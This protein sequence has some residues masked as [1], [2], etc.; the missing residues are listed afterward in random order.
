MPCA[1][2]GRQA[3][4]P[5]P[6]R[7]PGSRASTAAGVPPCSAPPNRAQPSPGASFPAR[8]PSVAGERV[9]PRP[10]RLLNMDQGVLQTR[11][12]PGA[13]EPRGRNES[14][15]TCRRGGIPR[16]GLLRFY[17]NSVG[18]GRINIV[19]MGANL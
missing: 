10:T 15:G 18:R 2:T 7:P 9:G 8:A 1:G 3:R 11:E 17:C 14:E 5:G 19:S 13:H 4:P 16:P 12:S 6:G